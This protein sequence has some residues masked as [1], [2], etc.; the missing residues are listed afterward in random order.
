[1]NL[2]R[3][4]VLQLAAGT[5]M[6]SALPVSLGA[7][8]IFTEFQDEETVKFNLVFQI[9]EDYKFS[10]EDKAALFGFYPDSAKNLQ[11]LRKLVHRFAIDFHSRD[12]WGRIDML[13]S[14]RKNLDTLVGS[15]DLAKQRAWLD[16]KDTLHFWGRSFRE[17]M[18]TGEYM[19]LYHASRSL[20]MNMSKNATGRV[21]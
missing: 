17:V 20:E 14:I 2:S 7:S 12:V 8:P 6:A 1:M 16:A 10:L 9:I 13:I 11:D 5:I 4:H 3:R 15:N 21:S 18:N 19:D